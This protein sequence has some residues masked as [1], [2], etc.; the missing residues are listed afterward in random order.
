MSNIVINKLRGLSALIGW[1]LVCVFFA[2]L[3]FAILSCPPWNCGGMG[4]GNVYLLPYLSFFTILPLAISFILLSKMT[5]LKLARVV[6]HAGLLFIIA[7]ALYFIGVLSNGAD[8]INLYDISWRLFIFL[9]LG[10]VLILLGRRI[11][12]K[13]LKQT[14]VLVKNNGCTD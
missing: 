5:R 9:I 14:R 3:G 7:P 2:A 1:F 12:V 11:T 13:E 6:F 8:W 4:D 10:V